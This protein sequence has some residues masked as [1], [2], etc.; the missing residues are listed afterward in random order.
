MN[1]FFKKLF[2]S[3]KPEHPT[4]ETIEQFMQQIGIDPKI[5]QFRTEAYHLSTLIIQ[6]KLTA[7]QALET[8]QD[9][10]L[11]EELT[12]FIYAVFLSAVVG[13][14]HAL[15]AIT[16]EQAQDLTTHLGKPWSI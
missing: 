16:S 2:D 11:R 5:E 9:N 13:G 15:G 12:P 8:V 6:Q 3:K 1:N 4:R 7:A 14:A 10:A